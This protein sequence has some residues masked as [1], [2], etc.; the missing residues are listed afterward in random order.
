RDF[1]KF[2]GILLKENRSIIQTAVECDSD[3]IF[4]SVLPQPVL[5]SLNTPKSFLVLAKSG[6][7]GINI[8]D[9]N[10]RNDK[11][12][13]YTIEWNTRSLINYG[14]YLLQEMNENTSKTH[15][16]SLPDFKTL[17]N[18]DDTNIADM[19]NEVQTP[20]ALHYFMIALIQEMN[21]CASESTEPFIATHENVKIASKK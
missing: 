17:V 12:S 6:T 14:D 8:R 9:A 5:N 16:K 10:F 11:F 7:D 20:R 3:I 21:G 1:N 15:C 2:Y 19:I 4:Q 13:I 18:Y